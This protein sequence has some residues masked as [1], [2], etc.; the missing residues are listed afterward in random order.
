MEGR[1][2]SKAEANHGRDPLGDLDPDGNATTSDDVPSTKPTS[3]LHVG[4][5]ESEGE[6]NAHSI[7]RHS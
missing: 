6:N 7:G 1:W 5:E 2:V 4:E 3:P